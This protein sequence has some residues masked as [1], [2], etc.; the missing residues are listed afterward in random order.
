MY[1]DHRVTPSAW[2]SSQSKGLPSEYCEQ[3]SSQPFSQLVWFITPV[4]TSVPS[5]HGEPVQPSPFGQ[6]GVRHTKLSCSLVG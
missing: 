3:P 4:I 5:A 2:N 1:R 6:C